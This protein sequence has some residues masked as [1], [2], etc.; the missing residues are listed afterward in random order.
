MQHKNKKRSWIRRHPVLFVLIA[1][2]FI[3]YLLN[4]YGMCLPEG[5]WLSE[6]E[7]IAKAKEKHLLVQEDILEYFGEE[8]G[9]Q[10]VLME[11][12]EPDCCWVTKD[13][14][15]TYDTMFSYS[16]EGYFILD[17]DFSYNNVDLV[18]DMPTDE[19]FLDNIEYFVSILNKPWFVSNCGNVYSGTEQ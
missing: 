3:L 9:K 14:Q 18:R 7:I 6:E 5:R 19:Y 10:Y 15:R 2:S 17:N 4:H 8:K 13:A 1:I 11:E 16:P 12:N